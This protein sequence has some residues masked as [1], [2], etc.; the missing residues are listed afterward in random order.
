M[1]GKNIFRRTVMNK[2]LFLMGMLACVLAFG[3]VLVGCGDD[4][5][6]SGVFKITVTGL[7]DYVGKSIELFFGWKDGNGGFSA[8]G[9]HPLE[10]TVGEDGKAIADYS[11]L[12]EDEDENIRSLRDDETPIYICI[13]GQFSI[14]YVTYYSTKSFKIKDETI[15]VPYSSSTFSIYI[16]E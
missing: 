14:Y 4:K 16:P 5:K 12:V 7:D 13:K 9:Y 6:N 15:E 10:V 3:L 11:D 1:E 2:K 8:S